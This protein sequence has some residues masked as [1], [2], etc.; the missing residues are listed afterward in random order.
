MKL[1]LKRLQ[2]PEKL[3]ETSYNVSEFATNK[4]RAALVFMLE[5]SILVYTDTIGTMFVLSSGLHA[6]HID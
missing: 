1:W 4:L 5:I 2:G 6:W 3:A